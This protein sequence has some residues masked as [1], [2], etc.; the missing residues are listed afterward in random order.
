MLG[1][2]GSIPVDGEKFLRYGGASTCVLVEMGDQTIIFDAGTGILSAAEA[3]GGA[4][5]LTVLL[6]H[7][8]ADHILGLAMF[9]PM[10]DGRYTVNILADDHLGYSTREQIGLLMKPP[11]W[12]CGVEVFQRGVT[13]DKL[14]KSGFMIGDVRV[15]WMNGSHPGG[16]SVYRLTYENTSIVYCTDF[17]HGDEHTPRLIEFAKGCDVMIYDAQYSPEEYETKKGFGHSTW[18][19]GILIAKACGVKRMVLTHHA[20]ERTDDELDAIAAV[21]AAECPVCTFARCGEEI[22]L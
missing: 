6:S 20:P 22:V 2:R 5:D 12:P 14:P 18:A 7:P 9:P 17:E 11:L 1:T 3:A 16:C 21:V 8:H 13:M 15:D 19:E 10:F 4:R